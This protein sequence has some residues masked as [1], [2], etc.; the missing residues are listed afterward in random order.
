MILIP[1]K[2]KLLVENIPDRNITKSGIYLSSVSDVPHRG[3][4][5]RLGKPFIDNGEELPWDIKEDEIVHFKRKWTGNKDDYYILNRDDVFAVEDIDSELRAVKD[6]VIIDRIYTNKIG[7]S[8]LLLPDISSIRNNEEGFY[9]DVISVGIY[10]NMGINKGDKIAYH[11][12]EGLLIKIVTG[13]EYWS[14]KPRA[15]LAL[16]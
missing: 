1:L 15:I 3:K 12:N 4:V 10:N 13:D 8:S 5:I 16:L 11:R 9:G 14:L 2:G 7:N 6:M